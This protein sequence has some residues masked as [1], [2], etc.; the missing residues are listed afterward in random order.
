[1]APKISRVVTY[2][3]EL[4]LPLNHVVVRGRVTIWIFHISTCTRPI[5]TKHGK[6]VIYQEGHPPINLHNTLNMRSRDV[7]WQI[8]NIVSPLSQY[9][10]SPHL[11]LWWNTTRNSHTHKCTWPL[12]ESVFKCYIST[13][14]RPLDTNLGRVLTYHERLPPLNSNDPLI[15]WPTWGYVTIRKTCVSTFRRLWPLNL[16]K[17][18]LWAEGAAGKHL[19]HHWLLFHLMKTALQ[20]QYFFLMFLLYLHTTKESVQFH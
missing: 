4:H 13:C 20:K 8:K 17:C 11:P 5:A 10:W 1:M 6:V 9:L 14:R 19:S 2:N 18:W 16:A 12:K 3:E 7:K 15:T